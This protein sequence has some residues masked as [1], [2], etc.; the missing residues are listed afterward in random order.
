MRHL[1]THTSGLARTPSAGLRAWVDYY[2]GRNP[3]ATA[4]PEA[5]L[6]RLARTRLRRRPG[7]GSAHY[8]N[9]GFGVLGIALVHAT[10]APD[11]NALVT[12]QVCVPLGLHRTA[13]D[14]PDVLTGHRGRY[15]QV[16]R[17]H[18]TGIAGAGA[19]VSCA[20]DLLTFLAAQLD[21]ASTT[22]AE[23]I[24]LTQAEHVGGRV[25]VGL[26]WM[27]SLKPHLLI[28]HNGGTGGYRSFA[29]F[30]PELG[31]GVVV[32]TNHARGVDLTG[33]NLLRAMD[34]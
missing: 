29:G 32:L 23:A 27:R 6:A 15:R 1:A 10:E 26:G 16:D 21:P 4:T 33:L 22:L 7:A 9:F 28:W 13:V 11:Y 14:L 25:A 8:S 20:S 17:W 2:R 24:E 30:Q 18:F 12:D 5:V 19:L 34:G 31:K 3:Y